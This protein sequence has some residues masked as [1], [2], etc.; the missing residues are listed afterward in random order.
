MEWAGSGTGVLSDSRTRR[1]MPFHTRSVSD[2]VAVPVVRFVV[3]TVIG[4]PDTSVSNGRMNESAL[5]L[6][7][8]NDHSLPLM[9][10]TRS[11]AEAVAAADVLSVV[12]APGVPVSLAVVAAAAVPA[13]R[14]VVDGVT[15]VTRSVLPFPRSAFHAAFRPAFGK[16]IA[17][18]G[19]H[20]LKHSDDNQ[21]EQ[22]RQR[23][24][25]NSSGALMRGARPDSRSRRA[26]SRSSGC[27]VNTT[28]L[29]ALR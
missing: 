25:C 15:T 9:I 27:S 4:R 7:A 12:L 5:K 6:H 16:S 1:S 20:A 19:G 29:A 24:H 3:D 28:A 11:V 23:T 26:L 17:A 22:R 10:A 21:A 2:A 14:S 8:R 13:S 18:N